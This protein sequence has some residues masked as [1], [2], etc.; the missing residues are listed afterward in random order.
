MKNRKNIL[1]TALAALLLFAFAA[2]LPSP[3]IDVEAYD[4]YQG[5]TNE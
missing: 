1:L 2:C 5:L 4:M 3:S